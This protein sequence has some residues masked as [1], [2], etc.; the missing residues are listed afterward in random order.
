MSNN[1]HRLYWYE[2]RIGLVITRDNIYVDSRPMN[3]RTLKAHK[4]LTNE[5]LFTVRDRDRRLQNMTGFQLTAFIV[6]PITG[7]RLVSKILDNTLINGQVKLILREGDLIN[8]DPGIYHVFITRSTTCSENLPLYK[9]QD[10]NVQF[11]IEITDQAHTAPIP[12]QEISNFIQTGNV[13][14]G[15]SEDSYVSEPFRGNINRNF[16]NAQ[17]TM[18]LFFDEYEGN[19]VI[20]ASCLNNVPD[21]DNTSNDWFDVET[22]SLERAN[23]NVAYQEHAITNFAV[24]CNWIRVVSYPETGS[25]KK[26][27]LRN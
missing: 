3:V 18:A 6:D 9:D 1:D 19:V 23:A 15:D 2:E 5:I 22:I 20:Q 25:I 12:T 13:L 24:N 21:T 26:L 10:N 27:V 8:L 4:G 16:T 11:D 7:T 14:I 17:H